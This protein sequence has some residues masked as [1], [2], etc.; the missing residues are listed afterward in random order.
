M[1]DHDDGPDALEQLKNMVEKHIGGP[2]EYRTTGV[3][4]AFTQ[5]D[6]F[7]R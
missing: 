1:A 5:M 7:M 3:K 4:R 6:N 2:I